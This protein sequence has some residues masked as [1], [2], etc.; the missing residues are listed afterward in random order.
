MPVSCRDDPESGREVGLPGPGR[1]EEHDVLCFEEEPSRRESGNLLPGR[2][3][4]VPVEVLERLP[5]REPGRFDPQLRAG[6]AD[7][8]RSRTA[9]R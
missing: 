1:A 3:L 8:S 7:T 2:G 9:A 6:G 4:R 5:G